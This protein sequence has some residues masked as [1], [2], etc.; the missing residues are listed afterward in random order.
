MTIQRKAPEL[1]ATSV[2]GTDTSPNAVHSTVFGALCNS[3]QIAEGEG[4]AQ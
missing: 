1:A 3:L 2:E 4:G